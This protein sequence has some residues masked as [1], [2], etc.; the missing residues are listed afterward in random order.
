MGYKKKTEVTKAFIKSQHLPNHGKSYTVI[1]H[2]E[3]IDNTMNIINASGINIIKE[4]KIRID[5]EE[6]ERTRLINEW[7]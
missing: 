5:L 4:V 3:V 6:K 2:K 1:S 7:Y